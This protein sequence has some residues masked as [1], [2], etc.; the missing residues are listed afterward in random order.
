MSSFLFLLLFFQCVCMPHQNSDGTTRP[1]PKTWNS[2][3]RFK[4]VRTVSQT[5][6]PFNLLLGTH[7]RALPD[8]ACTRMHQRS[9]L[10]LLPAASTTGSNHSWG[11]ICFE[12]YARFRT[13]IITNMMWPSW[14]SERWEA[15]VLV[16]HHSS[17]RTVTDQASS[18]CSIAESPGQ[19]RRQ[20]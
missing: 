10:Q 8:T 12:S 16:Q 6:Q 5:S 19:Q 1:W 15:Y 4:Y 20:C 9:R 14:D 17:S 13:A 7:L 11:Q 3:S 2:C 18:A